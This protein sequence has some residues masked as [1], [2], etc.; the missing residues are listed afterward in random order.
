MNEHTKVN[1][2][3]KVKNK[4]TKKKTK[5]KKNKKKTKDESTIIQPIKSSNREQMEW[6]AKDD[7]R[8]LSLAQE[9]TEDKQRVKRAVDM[10][11]KMAEEAERQA[12][13]A[14]KAIK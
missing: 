11:E 9:I 5:S 3:T 6:Q 14:K 12:Q 8:T 2:S 4:K 13:L 7:F 10:G 1:E